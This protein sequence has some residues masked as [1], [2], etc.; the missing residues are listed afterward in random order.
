M[1]YQG[2]LTSVGV[3]KE[4]TY[5]TGVSATTTGSVVSSTLAE[6]ST[7]QDAEDLHHGTGGVKSGPRRRGR[8]RP[9]GG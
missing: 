4:S 3:G 7:F 6:K 5:G 2:R 1:G 9:A 8:A